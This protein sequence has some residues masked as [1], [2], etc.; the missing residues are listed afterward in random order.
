M[1]AGERNVRLNEKA[2]VGAADVT[3]VD[4]EQDGTCLGPTYPY[5]PS[6]HLLEQEPKT[7]EKTSH[8]ESLKSAK[9]DTLSPECQHVLTD[10]TMDEEIEMEDYEREKALFEMWRADGMIKIKYKMRILEARK[11]AYES[12]RFPTWQQWFRN[13]QLIAAAEG[14]LQKYTNTEAFSDVR[15][16]LLARE[17][18]CS[19]TE[20]EERSVA[21][22]ASSKI[23]QVFAPKM[24]NSC[25]G[26][27][28]I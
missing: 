14:G 2:T 17:L 20:S 4:E 12:K 28:G 24:G 7:P 19:I 26:I 10:V 18:K 22:P 25:I 6:L 27:N 11:L 16:Q 3:L 9:E 15:N 13:N 1:S 23:H 5:Q 8:L 21:H